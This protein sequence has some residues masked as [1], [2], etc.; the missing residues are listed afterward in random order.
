MRLEERKFRENFDSEVAQIVRGKK[1]TV[2]KQDK[3][4]GG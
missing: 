4:D 2:D 1:A 3:Q